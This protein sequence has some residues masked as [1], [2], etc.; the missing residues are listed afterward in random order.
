MF[1]DGLGEQKMTFDVMTDDEFKEFGKRLYESSKR[2]SDIMK[3]KLFVNG[4]SNG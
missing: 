3:S 4:N 1:N 2:L